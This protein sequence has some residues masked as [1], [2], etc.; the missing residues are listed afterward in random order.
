MNDVTSC[1]LSQVL[2]AQ[3]TDTGQYVCVASNVV[4]SAEKS[5]NLNVHGEAGHTLTVCVCV[6]ACSTGQ[7]ETGLVNFSVNGWMV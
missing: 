4:G 5:F 3:V 7:T 1:V 6:C 2:N